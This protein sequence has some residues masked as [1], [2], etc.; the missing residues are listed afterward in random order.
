M[1]KLSV[2]R[3]N[4]CGQ[5][6][7][8]GPSA[9][10]LH[11]T[12]SPPDGRLGRV[13][14]WM[15]ILSVPVLASVAYGV[16]TLW[17]LSALLVGAVA[18]GVIL[19]TRQE[20]RRADLRQ[21]LEAAQ[22][23]IEALRKLVAAKD[24]EI[25][26]QAGEVRRLRSRFETLLET[27]PDI[28]VE[29]DRHYVFTMANSAAFRFYGPDLIGREAKEFLYYPQPVYDRSEGVLTGEVDSLYLEDWLR[30][31]DGACRLI[32]WRA[33]A[34]RDETGQ[35]VGILGVGRDITDQRKV[36]DEL[37][38]KDVLFR[39][40][41][42]AAHDAVVV[43]DHMG[44][45]SF[46]NQMATE[47]FGYTAEEVLGKEIHPL[48][49]PPELLPAYEKGYT[50]FAR[51]GEGAVVGKT[52]QLEALRKDKSRVTI[53]LSVG[54]FRLNGR[55]YAVAVIRDLSKL[56]RLEHE[57]KESEQKYRLLAENVDDIIWMADPEGRVVYVNTAVRTY[58]GFDPAELHGQELGNLFTAESWELLRRTI[59]WERPQPSD[60]AGNY[61]VELEHRT[62]WGETRKGQVRV[63]IVPGGE[64]QRR[65]ILGVSRITHSS[66]LPLADRLIDHPISGF[67]DTLLAAA[68]AN[69]AVDKI[70]EEVER[71]LKAARLLSSEGH[72]RLCR[73]GSH[74]QPFVASEPR[75]G[76]TAALKERGRIPGTRAELP[77]VSAEQEFI[78]S[79][80]EDGVEVDELGGA[81]ESGDPEESAEAPRASKA[82]IPGGNPCTPSAQCP[83]SLLV[84]VCSPSKELLGVLC[85]GGI[86]HADPLQRL[87]SRWV[88]P[89]IAMVL[90]REDQ[91]AQIATARETLRRKTRYLRVLY[92]LG[93]WCS[94]ERW[95]DFV[96][97]HELLEKIVA[98]LEQWV[99]GEQV[100]G[101]RVVLFGK[102]AQTPGFH[103]SVYKLAAPIY[104]NGELAGAVEVSLREAS[105]QLINSNLWREEQTCL[106]HLVNLLGQVLAHQ[107][108]RF[109]MAA[110][111]YWAALAI[112]KAEDN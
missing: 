88:A 10:T 48:V 25:A 29:V 55:Q 34:T 20:T 4:F 41:A 18:A 68:S 99:A 58:L 103:D 73:P 46:W 85:V 51:T 78:N 19:T 82:D 12:V 3:I 81:R 65:T 40:I 44:R 104:W 87:L 9:K 13:C 86:L 108:S 43:L 47:I 84:P 53:E 21:Q 5:G 26:R 60:W 45:A 15:L 6:R 8:S 39:A 75:G 100:G 37:Q 38:A 102:Q 112:S 49:C 106:S 42:S 95:T 107:I 90:E 101:I 36:E 80:R 96:D 105:A 97:E 54:A 35:I 63:R 11:P 98:L 76:R 89:V 64:G 22:A 2:C 50:T 24:A 23:E 70:L 109:A 27:I 69:E 74:E 59:G 79:P 30:R 67:V 61:L 77:R 52:L 110:S 66:E 111:G 1:G 92:E 16:G 71:F 28:V 93:E 91:A 72:V 56:K 57:L 94:S 33:R 62:A 83:G 7:G 17:F 14:L 32:A 31:H